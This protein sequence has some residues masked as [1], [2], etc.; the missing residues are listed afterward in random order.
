MDSQE[1]KQQFGSNLAAFSLPNHGYLSYH[2]YVILK[3]N[4]IVDGFLLYK[5][6]Q[7]SAIC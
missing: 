2:I 4:F 6:T 7:R 3:K 1:G 5:F